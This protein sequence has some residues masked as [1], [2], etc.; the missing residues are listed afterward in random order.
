MH[1]VLWLLKA[2]GKKVFWFFWEVVKR[3]EKDG[4]ESNSKIPAEPLAE[5]G[6]GTLR[7][8]HEF[9]S[10]TSEAFC[11]LIENKGVTFSKPDTDADH[12]MKYL[13]ADYKL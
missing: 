5:P 11:P 3:N 2:R 12:V 6:E 13:V 9:R 1:T 7:R 8:G 4:S 10:L